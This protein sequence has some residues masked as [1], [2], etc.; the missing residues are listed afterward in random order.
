MDIGLFLREYGASELRADANYR[1]RIIQT[2][3]YADDLGR[4]ALNSIYIVLSSAGGAEP[5]NLHC[6]VG[7]SQL[8]RVAKLS[9]G[10]H[11]TVRGRVTG[12]T[13]G[14]IIVCNCALVGP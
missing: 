5:T 4:D 8:Q 13:L 7:E 10:A 3:G 1:G 14:S 6:H 2:T 11:I 12:L 9:R